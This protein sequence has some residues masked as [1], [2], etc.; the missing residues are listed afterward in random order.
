MYEE[1]MQTIKVRRHSKKYKHAQ[2][3]STFSL[4]MLFINLK[5]L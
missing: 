4:N 5:I 2:D 1:E 3:M